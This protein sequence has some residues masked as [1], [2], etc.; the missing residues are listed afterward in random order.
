LLGVSNRAHAVTRGMA[1]QLFN[2]PAQPVA[3]AA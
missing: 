3:R 2:R 1:L